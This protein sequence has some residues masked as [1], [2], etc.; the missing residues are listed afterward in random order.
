MSMFDPGNLPDLDLANLAN[1]AAPE[2]FK[3]ELVDVLRNIADPNTDAKTVRSITL[4]VRFYPNAQRDTIGIELG[5]KSKTVAVNAA[6]GNA[7]LG[8]RNGKLVAWSA[9]FTQP[10]LFEKPALS[11][12]DR[13]AGEAVDR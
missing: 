3:R 6:A 7:I 2:L 4:E 13:R 12:A 8:K 1:G 9:D 5:C 10:E 11:V